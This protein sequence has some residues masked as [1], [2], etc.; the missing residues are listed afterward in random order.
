MSAAA[1][2]VIVVE[3]I[4]RVALGNG[5]AL[6]VHG[7]ERRDLDLIAA[8]WVPGAV[9]P[10]TLVDLICE[11]VGLRPQIAN[12]YPDGR[13][14]PNPEFKPFGRIAWSLV[15][16]DGPLGCEYV[17]LSVLPKAGTAFPVEVARGYGEI[18][19]ATAASAP[20]EAPSEGTER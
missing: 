9:E 17:D 1:T 16:T 10:L 20:G 12:V 5:Y 8:P 11:R 7:S 19:L 2:R 13:A 14:A 15:S 4:R 18:A 6:A 3:R